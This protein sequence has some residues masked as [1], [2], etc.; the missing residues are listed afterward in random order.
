MCFSQIG[1]MANLRFHT[2]GS[3]SGFGEFEVTDDIDSLEW[4][5]DGQSGLVL[6]PGAQQEPSQP[7][8]LASSVR[9]VPLQ[10]RTSLQLPLDRRQA[11][12]QA[13]SRATP[14]STPPPPNSALKL[15]F[16]CAE[17][18]WAFYFALSWWL[19]Q[20]RAKPFSDMAKRLETIEVRWK[21]L[22]ST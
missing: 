5:V 21:E 20:K 15:G 3:A 19:K 10:K 13:R 1:L 17:R 6:L 7:S 4:W 22:C 8:C 9:K 18:G 16:C 14:P 11:P 2:V 12:E